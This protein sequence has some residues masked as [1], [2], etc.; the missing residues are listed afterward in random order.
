MFEEP[1]QH[2]CGTHFDLCGI[3][4]R[5]LID[6]SAIRELIRSRLAKI[7][8]GDQYPYEAALVTA[9]TDILLIES[10]PTSLNRLNQRSSSPL[11]R[12]FTH[13]FERA[14]FGLVSILFIH[15]SFRVV[16]C[17]HCG[18]LTERD[19]TANRPL[20]EMCRW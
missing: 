8:Q 17:S 6:D 12:H 5:F 16:A 14:L 9:E 20:S 1:A 19:F 3:P 15:R 7:V 4:V 2:R 13:L 10:T 18:N 11:P